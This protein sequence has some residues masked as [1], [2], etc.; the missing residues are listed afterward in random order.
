[1]FRGVLLANKD[2][3]HIPVGLAWFMPD[4]TPSRRNPCGKCIVQLCNREAYGHRGEP[5]VSPQ[6]VASIARLDTRR[7]PQFSYPP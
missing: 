4:H 7:M 5:L 3:T 2:P 1:M 6:P